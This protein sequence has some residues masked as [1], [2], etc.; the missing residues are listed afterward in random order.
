MELLNELIINE[1]KICENALPHITIQWYQYL[2]HPHVIQRHPN[3]YYNWTSLYY[4]R[5]WES[6]NFS[7]FYGQSWDSHI[8]VLDNAVLYHIIFPEEFNE[9][10]RIGIRLQ[11]HYRHQISLI[12]FCGMLENI[13]QK[14]RKSQIFL[15]FLADYKSSEQTNVVHR[16]TTRPFWLDSI[17]KI[18]FLLF[19][20]LQWCHKEHNGISDHQSHNCLLNC[21]FRCW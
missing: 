17:S 15:C 8:N 19:K 11:F 12:M 18:F 20:T 10:S 5:I 9:K 3:L 2:F 16:W 14:V 7:K 6:I 1:S 21:L 13:A 4:H